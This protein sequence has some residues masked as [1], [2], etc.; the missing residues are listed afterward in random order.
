MLIYRSTC[1]DIFT[2]ITVPE[3]QLSIFH[4]MSVTSISANIEI[5]T[6]ISWVDKLN[7]LPILTHSILD[8]LLLAYLSAQPVSA[9]H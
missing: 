9:V 7:L 8:I 2:A 6:A 4:Q 3:M 1:C 5:H